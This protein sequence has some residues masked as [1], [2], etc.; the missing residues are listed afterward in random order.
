M[1]VE[2]EVNSALNAHHVLT[3]ISKIAIMSTKKKVSLSP[4]LC[5]SLFLSLSPFFCRP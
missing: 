2:H 4:C 5:L 3:V 1:P